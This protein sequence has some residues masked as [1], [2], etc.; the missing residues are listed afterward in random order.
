MYIGLLCVRASF[1]Y[2]SHIGLLFLYDVTSSCR[3]WLLQT[4]FAKSFSS[5]VGASALA[6]DWAW[7]VVA[8]MISGTMS[9]H[10]PVTSTD[11]DKHLQQRLRPSLVKALDRY[12]R[13]FRRTLSYMSLSWKPIASNELTNS[14]PRS[15]STPKES[16]VVLAQRLVF[17][18]VFQLLFSPPQS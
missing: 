17:D 18:Y 4:H 2:K 8:R 11:R 3:W 7:R 15:G 9:R 10:Q 6:H 14:C 5:N 13:D 1:H 16:F 12:P